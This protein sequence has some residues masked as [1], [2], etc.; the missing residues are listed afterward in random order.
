MPRNNRS[1]NVAVTPSVHG[2]W[3]GST[4]SPLELLTLKSF[5]RWGHEFNLWLYDD[6]QT[7]VPKG[8]NL[9]DACE[10]LPRERIFRK[11]ERDIETGVGE[12]SVSPFSD[13]FRYKLLYE[14]GGIWADMD[15]TCLRRFDLAE[16]YLFRAHRLGMVGNLMKCPKGSALMQAC[17]EESDAIADEN[18][19]WLAQVRILNA[20]VERLGLSG[21]IRDDISNIDSWE[22][23]IRYFAQ[24]YTPI[25]DNWYAIHWGNELWRTLGKDDG[26]YHGKKVSDDIPDKDRPPGGSTLHEL[27]RYY[28]LADVREDFVRPE[29]APGPL[30]PT[31]PIGHNFRSTKA[32]LNMVLPALARGGA[33]RIA[34]ETVRALSGQPDIGS[35]VYIIGDVQKSYVAPKGPNVRVRSF[36]GDWSPPTFRRIAL[37]VASSNTPIAYTHLLRAHHLSSL[38]SLGVAT[39]P[40]VHNA[41]PAWLDS[42]TAY[43]NP[44]VPY[45]IAVADAVADQLKESGCTR[46]IVTIRH[47]LQRWF[48]PG[49]MSRWRRELRAA[50]GV[51]DDT[52]LIGMVGQFKSQKAYTRAVR[53]L[54]EVQRSCKAKLIILGDWDHAYGS[55]RTTFEAACRL[56]LGLGVMPDLILPGNVDPV[57]PYFAAFDVYLNTSVFEGLSIALLEALRAG[58]P[59]VAA[60]A[61]GNREVMPDSAVL[62][63]DSA[64]IQAY[65]DGILELRTRGRR[66][67][68]A[69]PPEPD[70]IPRLWLSLSKHGL[71]VRA[72]SCTEPSGTMF[73]TDGLH[74]GGPAKSLTNL[75]TRLPPTVKTA[76]ALIN[77]ASVGSFRSAI[78][79]AQV[80]ILDLAE[81]R[82]L[83]NA[84]DKLLSWF[85]QLNCRTLCFWNVG[86]ELKL[87]LTKILYHRSVR[88]MDVSPGPML[89][90]ELADA[91]PFQRRLAIDADDYLSRLDDFV[92]LYSD[93][94][95]KGPAQPRR[96]WVIPLGAAPPARFVPLPPPSLMLP[97]G[98][99]PALAIG[100]CC[101]IVPDKKVEFLLDMMEDLRA[102]APGASLTIVGGPDSTSG[103]YWQQLQERV[104]STKLD[105]VRF[106]GPHE[107]VTPFLSQLQVF[108]M[109][110]ERQGCPNASLEA[111]AMGLPVIANPDGGT[112]EQVV[113]GVTGYLARSPAIM[114]A[115]VAELLHNPRKRRELGEA[116]RLRLRNAFSIDRMVTRYAALLDGDGSA[117][118]A[119]RDAAPS[120]LS[121]ELSEILTA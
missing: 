40:V 31:Q 61:G 76:L 3:I 30:R 15:I 88:L 63:E 47:E 59:V 73:V 42:P 117:L 58:C 83:S 66:D 110:G 103:D 48:V 82:G 18:V 49:E 20:N 27:Y 28:G 7:S 8:V 54:A 26:H 90:D 98:F 39:V 55:G 17:Y 19:D 51:A 57:E 13:L 60:N 21:F 56:A 113:D 44:N 75:L 64:D 109:V 108:V 4:L 99:D 41:R 24:H 118:A 29:A 43:N 23:S 114:A 116:G 119:D 34:I 1:N 105:C 33:E 10:I 93:G 2:L 85:D 67:L 84:A 107:D 37:E 72:G 53:V 115:R 121:T 86:P 9:R 111:M 81:T 45:V 11:R 89:F 16:D 50:H 71:D 100:T 38:W 79:E 74:I 94:L 25:P 112:S 87:L 62:V 80:P 14:H 32:R 69:P 106:V 104:H 12:G 52:L 6:L 22:H 95:P 46:P 36:G 91:E 101:R 5:V 77:G 78:E 35:S 96:S 70:L 102:R 120:Q 65:V 92:S 68:P 97:E